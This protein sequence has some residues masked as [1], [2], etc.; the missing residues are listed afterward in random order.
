M[1]KIKSTSAQIPVIE[2]NV[3]YSQVAQLEA[4][5]G[6]ELK[7]KSSLLGTLNEMH[8]KMPEPEHSYSAD[9]ESALHIQ[10][11]TCLL[12]ERNYLEIVTFICLY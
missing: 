5:L 6:K 3:I 9:K 4:A 11:V 12:F 10:V 1:H 7:E 8:Q 2:C